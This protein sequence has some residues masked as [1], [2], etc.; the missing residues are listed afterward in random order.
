MLH[1]PNIRRTFCLLALSII[2][3][4]HTFAQSN[5]GE[6]IPFDKA[7]TRGKLP[8]GFCYYIRHNEEPKNRVTIYL[9]NKVGSILETDAQQGLA[10]FM[11]HMS[12]NGTKH[13][14]KNQ[15]I[16]YL[17]KSGVKF[18]SDLNAY[19][20]YDETV[21]Q[22]PL[23]TDNP[24]LLKNGFQ[25][26]RDWAQNA[27][28]DATEIEKERGVVLEEKRL[29]SNA[30]QRLQDA[31]FPVLANKS[32]YAQRKPI[33]TEEVLK[34]FKRSNIL[35][36]YNKWYRPNLQAIIV[37]GDIDVAATEKTIK[38]M[39]GTLKNP[40]PALP[41]KEYKIPLL[42]KAQF[43]Q[44]TDP[45]IPTTSIEII[46]KY[47]K[48]E[49][50]TMA[51]YRRSICRNLFN[52]IMSERF[53]DLSKQENSPFLSASNGSSNFLANLDANSTSISAET[54]KLEDAVR[55][56]WMEIVR[57][58]Q[59]GFTAEE[60]NRAKQ[61]V[62]KG[63]ESVYNE[64]TKT[65][66]ENYVNEYVRHFLNGEAS[67]GIAYELELT[68]KMLAE[69]QLPE[70]NKCAKD[71]LATAPKDI[72]LIAPEK[73][74][75]SLPSEKDIR[76]WIEQTEKVKITVENAENAISELLPVKP[77]AGKI[78]QE[79]KNVKLGTTELK[80]ENGVKV[81]LKPTTFKDDEI[82]FIA[83][84]PGGFSLY[85][86]KDYMSATAATDVVVTA[87][88]GDFN[89][90]QLQ[91]YL[92]GKH[93]EVT[94]YINDRF[95]GF[96]GSAAPA[97]LETAMQMIYMYFTNPRKDFQLIKTELERAKSTLD[98]RYNDP[99]NVFNDTVSTVV[100]NYNFRRTPPSVE[101]INQI[102]TERAFEIYKERFA[103]ASDFTF[104]FVGSFDAEKI[105]PLLAQYL[106]SLPAIR[107]TEQAPDL[108]IHI[109]E[110]KLDKKVYKGK[111]NKSTVRLIFSG[112]YH[113]SNPENNKLEALADL[114]TIKLIEKLREEESGVY[115]V[116]A[117]ARYSKYPHNRYAI[118][119]SFGCAPANVEKLIQSTLNEIHKI[120]NNLP[121]QTDLE[122]VVSEATRAYEV[123]SQAN[124]FWLNYLV[125]QQQSDENPED[126]FGYT[127]Q[128]KSLTPAIMQD[129]AKTYFNE[130]N[131][132]RF[133]LYPGK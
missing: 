95:E 118:S 40:N 58:Q 79:N 111:D 56:V 75:A 70:L 59:T 104:T 88:L 36:F 113:Y 76:N 130:N 57:T 47:K 77:K 23:P 91:K 2:A 5:S 61:S 85:S 127:Q 49:L 98:N 121:Q 1:K 107:R 82:N 43:A 18:G 87:G 73:D 67:P 9:V 42:D 14:P 13:F 100:G 25:I 122:K 117:Y 6:P 93:G 86:N 3:S 32:L 78:I 12:F 11:E 123:D 72:L 19:T 63:I 129:A 112:T 48:E 37:V 52:H 55:A 89:L 27:T 28:L 69:I 128:L 46:Q 97:D 26:M 94:P 124:K 38:S 54:S 10:H 66:S 120:Q 96:T 50:K 15:L 31:I 33:G 105:K 20:S 22:L 17:Q 132:A 126:I 106:G 119:I 29:H 80:F 81:V 64:R 7:V 109:P 35:D 62:K 4:A 102:N 44:F 21:Y 110:G 24:E 60:L 115:G 131:F 83:S 68:T 51:D 45:E 92:T 133:V 116:G 90:S 108:N 53:S 16:D 103:D 65:A 39:F 114:L 8:N 101:K 41:R 99:A 125:G 30:Q 84:S 71:Y 34:N 74:A